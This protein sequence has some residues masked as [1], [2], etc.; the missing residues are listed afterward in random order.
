M[1]VQ[2][3]K[4]TVS[5]EAADTITAALTEYS[6]EELVR[7]RA[8]VNEVH[9]GS[10]EE[11]IA[12]IP[13]DTL[14]RAIYIGYETP[15]DKLAEYIRIH[16]PKKNEGATP[17]HAALNRGRREGARAAAEILSVKLPETFEDFNPK[18]A[19]T[20]R[21]SSNRTENTKEVK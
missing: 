4:V 3:K 14:A 21:L 11:K 1:T 12:R 5:Q 10:L 8:T 16:T 13:F 7:L 19:E 2:L 18:G 6:A 17:E 15:A 20:G 9:I